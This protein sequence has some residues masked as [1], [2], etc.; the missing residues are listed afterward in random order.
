M[1]KNARISAPL[2]IGPPPA[3]TVKVTRS[4]QAAHPLGQP[5]YRGKLS[6]FE[7]YRVRP[8]ALLV[9]WQAIGHFFIEGRGQRITAHP[10]P[11]VPFGRFRDLLLHTIP[12]FALLARGIETLHASC[13]ARDGAAVAFLGGPGSG[14]STLAAVLARRG[15]TVLADDLLPVQTRGRK[16]LA[17][18]SC[19]EIK[20]TRTA[21]RA[22]GLRQRGL[23][24]IEPRHPKRLW[25]IP[26]APG[27]RPLAALY[28][29][30]LAGSPRSSVRLTPVSSAMAF[31]ALLGCSYNA[32]LLARGRLRRQFRLFARIARLPA[33]RLLIPRGLDRLNEVAERVERDL[34]EWRG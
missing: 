32:A 18:P 33:R 27:P 3:I 10:A 6:P 1:S 25:R 7:L 31:R 26:A 8:E 20:L 30:R 24:P 14:K 23:V 12:S 11:S 22:L 17:Y 9:R 28:F 29:P 21:S 16:I 5:F 15:H 34:A 4:R 19:P 13:A 2:K